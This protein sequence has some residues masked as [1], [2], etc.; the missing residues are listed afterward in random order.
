M[1]PALLIA[2]GLLVSCDTTPPPN[3]ILITIDTLRADRVGAYGYDEETTPAID[4]LAADSRVFLQATTPF[5]RTTPAM[6]SLFTGLRPERHGSREIWQ[7]FTTGTTLA[8]ILQAE[9]YATIGVSAN[10]AAGRKQHL[11]RGFDV[12]V[13]LDEATG[14]SAEEV[15]D[16][17]LRLT[18]GADGPLFLWV[19]YMDPHFPYLPPESQAQPPAPECHRLMDQIRDG[20]FRMGHV[21]GD[22]LGIS[23]R[24]LSDCS[25][26]YDAEIRYADAQ[27]NRLLDSLTGRARP[28]GTYTILTS[29]HGE[30][31]GEDDLFFGHGPS[32]HDAAVRVPLIVQGPGVQ[33]GQDAHPIRL[34]DVAP[35]LLSLLGFL[36]EG[37]D[38][39]GLDQSSRW[40]GGESAQRP[41][42]ARLA[43]GSALN[44]SYTQRV[45]SGRA[46]SR[47]C[48]HDDGFSL[49]AFPG[50]EIHLFDHREDPFLQIDVSSTYPDI[51]QRLL[52]YSRVWQPEHVRERA[53]RDA[54][55]KL[56]E[57]PRLPGGYDRLLYDLQS[58]TA[59][60]T[61]VRAEFPAVARRL[62]AA[63]E[64]WQTEAPSIR[65]VSPGDQKALRSL[66]YIE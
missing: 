55:F 11:D 54:R 31:L 27:I 40:Q 63:L 7:P 65:A 16:A 12:F 57:R 61:D 49:C 51:R 21:E 24:S 32:L 29:D 13:E 20:H 56:L 50:R 38:L 62:D 64:A 8:E 22:V 18:R 37:V 41:D 39:D 3:V 10:P 36:P 9:G 44:V 5:P 34:E 58:D 52:G 17:A 45:F 33:A 6:A 23:S 14:D 53:V 60:Q 19:H 1:F 26:L 47:S 15:T 35:T 48:I 42:L 59:E 43:G 25:D 2:L 28:A 46:H 30:N 66:G 4:R